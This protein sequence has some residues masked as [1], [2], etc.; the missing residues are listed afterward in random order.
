MTDMMDDFDLPREKNTDKD[1][2]FVESLARGLDVLRAFS[3]KGGVLGNQDIAKITGLP[4]PTVSRMTY[5]LMELGYLTFSTQLEKYQLDA[6]VLALG[7]AYTSN[8]QVR[9]IAKPIMESLANRVNLSVGLTICERISMLYVENCRGDDSQ[10]LRMEVGSSLP[11]ATSAAGRAYLAGLSAAEREI[12]LVRLEKRAGDRWDELKAGVDDALAE[13]D[14]H[15]FCTSI[16]AWDKSINGVGVPLRL[17]NGRVLALNCG[18]P[19]YLVSP[20]M[21]KESL[22][23]QLVHVARDIIATG[24]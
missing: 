11:V 5:T 17:Q 21:A 1:R 16:G 8:L 4:K 23:P 9:R 6:G 3:Q 7:Y 15:G 10:A 18:G 20:E 14:E 2:K 19:A 22:G 24:V 12:M 13:Y